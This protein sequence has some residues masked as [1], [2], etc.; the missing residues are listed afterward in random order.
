MKAGK[1][2]DEELVETFIQDSNGLTLFPRCHV[3]GKSV[4]ARVAWQGE[5]VF[6]DYTP[7]EARVSAAMHRLLADQLDKAAGQAEKIIEHGCDGSA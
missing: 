1:P 7:A 4:I 3:E 5:I 6:E 2:T